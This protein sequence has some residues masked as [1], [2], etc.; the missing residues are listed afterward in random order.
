MICKRKLKIMIADKIA[1][2]KAIRF[3]EAIVLITDEMVNDVRD[4]M[5]RAAELEIFKI[6]LKDNK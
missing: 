3:V 1:K 5:M 4:E 2:K 6:E